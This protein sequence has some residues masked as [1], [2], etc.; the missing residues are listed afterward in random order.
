MDIR[1]WKNQGS[2]I[3]QD[4]TGI[5]QRASSIE[6]TYYKHVKFQKQEQK[7]QGERKLDNG[8]LVELKEREARSQI[9]VYSSCPRGIR[10]G[11]DNIWRKEQ[12]MPLTENRRPV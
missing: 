1:E 12:E 11:L 8:D 9:N 5:R 4:P 10:Q 3:Q 7:L 2:P 6:K